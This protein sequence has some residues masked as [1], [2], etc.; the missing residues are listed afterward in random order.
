MDA[1]KKLKTQLK[2]TETRSHIRIESLLRDISHLKSPQSGS[3]PPVPT[4]D[5][6][7]LNAAKEG[8]ESELAA[9]RRDAEEVQT[10]LKG[11][12]STLEAQLSDSQVIIDGFK[13]HSIEE[14]KAMQKGWHEQK[15]GFE[16]YIVE[17]EGLLEREREMRLLENENH[18]VDGHVSH[19]LGL[20]TE[21]A[22]VGKALKGAAK[23]GGNTAESKRVRDLEKLVVELQEKLTRGKKGLLRHNLTEA[24]VSSKPDMDE[25]TYVHHLKE[26]VKRL[27]VE[28][29]ELEKKY[30]ERIEELQNEVYLSIYIYTLDIY[31]IDYFLIYMF[32][33]F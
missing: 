27:E 28:R 8:L 25:S 31:L 2:E 7:K 1:N 9:Y 13:G 23:K 18:R 30:D 33:D 20:K 6:A 15:L 16:K 32:P 19:V 17:L 4:Y 22:G 12:I 11:R 14:V 29:D 5:I 10:S 3:G 24:L 26:K 21:N